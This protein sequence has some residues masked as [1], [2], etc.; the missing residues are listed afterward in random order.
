MKRAITT[1]KAPIPRGPYSQ[2]IVTSGTMVYVAGQ[3]PIS[4]ETQQFDLGTIEHETRLVMDNLKAI[5]EAAGTDMDHVVKTGIF[6]KDLADFGAMNAVY[7]TYFSAEPPARSTVQA[8]L[9][10]GMKVEIDCVAVLPE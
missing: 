9:L 4:L 8:E 2:A 5:L 3:C 7:G 10:G 1:D 6:L